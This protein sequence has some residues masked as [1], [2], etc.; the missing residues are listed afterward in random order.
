M[1]KAVIMLI[2]IIIS[3]LTITFSNPQIECKKDE[4]LEVQAIEK[5][6]IAK[7]RA[8]EQTRKLQAKKDIAREGRGN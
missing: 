8:S 6:C 2:I 7:E 5:G 3:T 4:L 1:Q